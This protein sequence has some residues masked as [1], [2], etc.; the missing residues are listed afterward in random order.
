MQQL[1]NRDKD[2]VIREDVIA[3]WCVAVKGGV[4]RKN[5]LDLLDSCNSSWMGTNTK[6]QEK[7]SPP[8]D[9]YK[10]GKG[11]KGRESRSDFHETRVKV[12]GWV[13]RQSGS[14]CHHPV[15]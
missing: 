1:V 10:E 3:L 12:H 13:Q 15:A 14:R 2:K 5:G 8:C 6:L 7:M 11:G 4:A 9:V